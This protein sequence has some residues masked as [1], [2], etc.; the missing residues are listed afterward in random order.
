[1]S[2][3]LRIGLRVVLGSAVL[4]ALACLAICVA[5]LNDDPHSAD[6]GVVLG[7]RVEPDGRPSDQLQARIDEAAKLYHAGYFKLVLVSGGLGR[8]GHSE[9]AVMRDYLIRAGVPGSSIIEDPYGNDTY[10]TARNTSR[11]LHQRHLTSILVISQYFHLPR[12]RLAFSRYGIAPVY[13]ANAR[14]FSVRDF[15]SVPREV[16][17][18]VE[19][20]VRPYLS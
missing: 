16:I 14:F 4:F 11:L 18:F 2:R 19:Y 10:L 20:L 1:V 9:P 5:G 17:G 13:T 15:Y 7:N 12:C 8:E 3:I 6:L